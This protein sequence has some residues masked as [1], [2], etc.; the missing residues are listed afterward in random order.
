MAILLFDEA[1]VI[2]YTYQ[3]EEPSLPPMRLQDPWKANQSTFRWS[4]FVMV[5][6]LCLLES[7]MNISVLVM[8]EYVGCGE[9]K[10]QYP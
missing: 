2:E 1:P 6:S 10:P 3:E 5:A 8:V 7:T 9:M 4:D